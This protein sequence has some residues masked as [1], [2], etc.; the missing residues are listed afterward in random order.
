MVVMVMNFAQLGSKIYKEDQYGV[1]PLL[2][3]TSP[4]VPELWCILS[5]TQKLAK[6]YKAYR[7]GFWVSA[8]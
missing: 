7:R 2:V 6:H 4:L 5:M 8:F 1:R 3:K